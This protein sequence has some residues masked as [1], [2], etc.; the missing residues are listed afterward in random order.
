MATE[1]QI[2]MC[3]ARAR[4]AK[5]ELKREDLENLNNGPDI[6]MVLK[7]IEAFAKEGQK[8]KEVNQPNS[9]NFNEARFGMCAKL[10]VQN[11]NIDWCI[12]EREQFVSKV[13]SLYISVSHAAEKV[14]E[15]SKYPLRSSQ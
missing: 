3:L 11:N 14:M 15:A 13:L 9:N 4:A 12:A 2:R 1:Q 5:Y 6:D 8:K 7:D 10:V